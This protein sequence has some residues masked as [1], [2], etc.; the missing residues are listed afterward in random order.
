MN[1]F[2]TSIN[3]SNPAPILKFFMPNSI[4]HEISF[5]HTA[6]NGEKLRFSAFKLSDDAFIML[7][8]VG[9]Y[10]HDRLHAELS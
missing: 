2:V 4:D 6:L 3:K 7:I 10:K 1:T 5:A 9:I 8:N